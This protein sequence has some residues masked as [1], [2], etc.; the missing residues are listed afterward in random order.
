[1]SEATSRPRLGRGLSAL[2]GD[3]GPPPTLVTM[4]PAAAPPGT[5]AALD[6]FWIACGAGDA[7]ETGEAGSRGGNRRGGCAAHN[8]HDWVRAGQ[9]NRL[10]RRCRGRLL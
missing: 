8:R 7:A 9:S 3:D 2:L 4:D 1:M 10:R 5:D 6:A